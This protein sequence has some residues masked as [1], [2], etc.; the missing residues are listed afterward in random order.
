MKQPASKHFAI[1]YEKSSAI[2]QLSDELLTTIPFHDQ[3]MTFCCIGTDRSTGDSLGPLVGSYLKSSLSFPFPIIGTLQAPLHALNLEETANDLQAQQPFVV[4]IDAC[5]A[6]ESAVGL[7]VLNDGPIFPGKAVKKQLPPIGN[8]AIKGVVNVGGFMEAAILQ[9]TRLHVTQT[10][11][12][13]IAKAI[14]LAWQRYLLN[15]KHNR[16]NECNNDDAWQ[17]IGYTNFR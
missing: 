16:D 15:V 13:I 1:H 5:L 3:H 2:W 17:Q 10:M 8:I 7:I 4:A 14:L 9:N 11:S 12:T 6:E